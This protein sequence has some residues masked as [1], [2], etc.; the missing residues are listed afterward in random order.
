MGRGRGRR[1]VGLGRCIGGRTWWVGLV[2][3]LECGGHEVY[4]RAM[5]SLRP[6]HFRPSV[7]ALSWRG[8]HLR[9]FAACRLPDDDR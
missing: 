8:A 6:V 4:A 1:G 3:C 7:E 2:W 9:S 5:S